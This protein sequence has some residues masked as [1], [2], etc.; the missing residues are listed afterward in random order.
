MF[1]TYHFSSNNSKKGF[2]VE[3]R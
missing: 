2:L 3:N 1:W